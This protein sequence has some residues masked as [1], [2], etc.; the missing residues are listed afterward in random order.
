MNAFPASE[1]GAR[2]V[3][4]IIAVKLTGHQRLI[5]VFTQN[6]YFSL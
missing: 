5:K 1:I 3:V 2:L 4:R 6:P